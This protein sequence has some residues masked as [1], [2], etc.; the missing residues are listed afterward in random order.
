MGEKEREVTDKKT[1]NIIT[2][3]IIYT[4]L[5][6]TSMLAKSSGYFVFPKKAKLTKSKNSSKLLIH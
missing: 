4:T 5:H 6:T 1:M 3:T 2:I